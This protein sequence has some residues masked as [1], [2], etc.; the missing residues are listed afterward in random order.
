MKYLLTILI[1]IFL[2]PV[3][4]QNNDSIQKQKEKEKFKKLLTDTKF[5]EIK[6]KKDI[7]LDIFKLIGITSYDYID[8]KTT[9]LNWAEKSKNN[10]YI[11]SLKMLSCGFYTT[12]YVIENNVPKEF[13][14]NIDKVTFKEFRTWAINGQKE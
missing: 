13:N 9:T 12:H 5:K 4:G 8:G 6:S 11:I 10:I 14:Y 7:P 2:L 1:S 3:F